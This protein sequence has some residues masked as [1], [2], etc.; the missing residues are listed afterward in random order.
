[1]TTRFSD[2]LIQIQLSEN[3]SARFC[4]TRFGEVQLIPGAPRSGVDARPVMGEGS[5]AHFTRRPFHEGRHGRRGCH[6]PHAPG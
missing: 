1:M 2:M 5:V 6:I 3:G 4:P